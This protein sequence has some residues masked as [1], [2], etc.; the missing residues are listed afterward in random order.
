MLIALGT[1]LAPHLSK[2]VFEGLRQMAGE[3]V[4]TPKTG[5][6]AAELPSQLPSQPPSGPPAQ[7]GNVGA[8]V[9][10]PARAYRPVRDTL[11]RVE[12]VAAQLD[13]VA[14]GVRVAADGQLRFRIRGRV[15]VRPAGEEDCVLS[16]ESE[17]K[18]REN[19][20]TGCKHTR[21]LSCLH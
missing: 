13:G 21:K 7:L 19:C 3:F 10:K 20:R 8:R 18:S 9:G 15:H 14:G 11:A 16:M 6:A 2:A 12:V 17:L 1:G 4:R 5:G